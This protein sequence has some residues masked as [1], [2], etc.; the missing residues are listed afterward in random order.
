MAELPACNRPWME[1]SPTL[2]MKKSRTTMNVP[3]RTTGRGSHLEVV[4]PGTR[5]W[6]ADVLM[7]DSLPPI[8]NRVDYL[9]GSVITSRVMARW[10]VYST[11][12]GAADRAGAARPRL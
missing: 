7:D 9:S 12:I 4:S 6:I 8:G 11:M 2:T 3:A 5:D 1:G 10:P